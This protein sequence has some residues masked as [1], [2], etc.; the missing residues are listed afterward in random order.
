MTRQRITIAASA[1]GLAV[2]GAGLAGCGSDDA[3]SEPPDA[4]SEP[5][6]PTVSPTVDVG[7]DGDRLGGYVLA[8]DEFG[9]LTTV[10][11]TETTRTI[12][13]N[14]LPD[15]ETGEFP[16][17]G[18]PNAI[19]AQDRTW[20]FP[21]QP[22]FVGDQT[23]VMVPGVAV[24]GIKFEPE[25]AET[26]ECA[27][28]ETYRV[29]ALQ[30]TYDLGFDVNN[31]HVQPT[32][33][34]HYHGASQLLA[35]AAASDDDLVHV[36]FAA[37]GYLMYYSMSG[38]YESGWE[39]STQPRTGTNCIG[40]GALGRASVEVEGTLPDGV[41]VSDWL[42]DDAVGGLDECNGITIDGQYVYLITDDYPFVPRCLNG[43]VTGTRA[44]ERG[45]ALPAPPG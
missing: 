10:T 12:V 21:T 19:S 2:L 16:N 11:V 37:D 25:T 36:G 44:P 13:T 18:N 8:D 4:I 3:I 24:N 6:D 39:L 43:D 34:Y 31:A 27:T 23:W 28:G 42:F 32:G 40:S 15:H 14:A 7:T 41:Y 35:E 1:V 45:Q 5:P 22:T 30:D 33:E 38:A 17:S 20:E 26:V 29:E 9:T